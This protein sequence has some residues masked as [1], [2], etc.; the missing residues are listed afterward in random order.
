MK[1]LYVILILIILYISISAQNGVIYENLTMQSKIL[2]GKVK[3]DIYLP[4]DYNI[5]QRLYPVVYLLHGFTDDNTAWVQFGEIQYTMDNG[6]KDGNITPMII[7]MPDAKVS[8]YINDYQNN[9]PFEDMFIKEFIPFIENKYRIRKE[10]S[11]RAVSGLSMGGWGSLVY[12]LKHPD[13]FYV[14]APISAAIWTDSYLVNLEDKRYERYFK[15][16]FGDNLKGKERLN[17]HYR[18]NNPIDLAK[19]LDTKTLNSIKFYITCGDDDAL[20]IGNCLLHQILLEKQ[21]YHEF[22]IDDGGHKWQY[23]RSHVKEC[24]MFISKYFHR[25]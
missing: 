6:I 3:Y 21:V 14:C 15:N 2:N 16:I 8:W 5:S 12:A 17:A 20:S 18:N 4:P 23:F 25:F 13:L 7:V 11:Y 24:L 22:R 19:K 10:K 1:N 9:Y